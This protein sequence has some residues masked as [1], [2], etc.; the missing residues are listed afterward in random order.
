MRHL[1]YAIQVTG[2][3]EGI[4]GRRK[5]TVQTEYTIRHNGRHGQIIKGIREMF[6]NVGVAVLAQAFVVKA[7]DLGNLSTLVVTPQDGDTISVSDF[8]SHEQGDGF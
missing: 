2:V 7:V 3:I 8:K 6:P 4:N 1:L 5:S